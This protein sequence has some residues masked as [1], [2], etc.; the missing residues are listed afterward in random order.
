MIELLNLAAIPEKDLLQGCAKRILDL[1]RQSGFT[2]P[3][4]TY[5]TS[6]YKQGEKIIYL[7]AGQNLHGTIGVVGIT[8][9]DL[10]FQPTIG[11]TEFTF[12]PSEGRMEGIRKV[13]IPAISDYL[14]Y[15]GQ[16]PVRGAENTLLM[17]E[18]TAMM[19]D[20]FPQPVGERQ[21]QGEPE[22]I[23]F[24]I[25]LTRPAESADLWS[26]ASLLDSL[27]RAHLIPSPA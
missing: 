16:N 21:L 2:D 8:S 19:Q 14:F 15:P 10:D 7:S 18:L 26:L 17:A 27:T 5:A 3:E 1:S 11:T 24:D 13:C 20:G 22:K 25:E 4:T 6:V 9:V 12:F 23:L